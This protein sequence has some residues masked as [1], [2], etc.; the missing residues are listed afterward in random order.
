[1]N[2]AQYASS[3]QSG[4]KNKTKNQ[5]NNNNNE[6]PKKK[7]P[8][9]TT[10]KNP[11]RKPKFPCLIFGEDHFTR[12]CPHRDK[13]AKLFKGNSQPV[14]LTQP[15]PQ[16]KSMVGQALSPPTK[17]ASSHPPS[18]EASTNAH[19]Y[20][21]NGIDLTI[22]TTTYDT[23]SKPDKE[24]VTNGTPPDPSPASISPP[25]GSLQIEKPT[26]DSI[27]L[28]P[29]RTIHNSRVNPSSRATRNYNIVEDLA[30]APCAIFALEVLQH[31]PSQRRTLLAAIGAI[32]PELSNNITF[33]LDNFK[34]RLSHQHGFQIGVV[35]HNQHIHH[36]ILD[37]GDMPLS[38]VEASY[39]ALDDAMPLSP[40][41][42]SY[43]AIQSASPSLG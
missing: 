8:P 1:V 34:S 42:A 20:M 41:E 39:D 14:V 9:P 31:F 32:D 16:Q 33:N 36:T 25:Y 29:K 43:N 37:E 21:F 27:L 15:F 22:P 5:P 30:Q 10:E 12:D 19:I 4:G 6:H 38:P 3:Q 11:Q 35:V 26:F 40:A 28:P 17:G 24:K 13:V 7:N 23:P 18:D 2:A